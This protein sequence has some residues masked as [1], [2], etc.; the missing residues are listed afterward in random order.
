LK[1]SH[2]PQPAHPTY[3]RQLTLPDGVLFK[4]QAGQSKKG[5]P[6]FAQDGQ[7]LTWSGISLGK[8]GATQTLRL[9]LNVTNCAEGQLA[10]AATNTVAGACSTT[11]TPAMATV[12]HKKGTIDRNVG[13]VCSL[14]ES[15]RRRI[16]LPPRPISCT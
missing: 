6:T 7:D 5:A 14:D 15:K 4:S 10:F 3:P 16:A 9:K 12:R 2:T 11:A 8:R 13:H 1:D